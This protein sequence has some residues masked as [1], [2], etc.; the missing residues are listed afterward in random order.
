MQEEPR[1]S[2]VNFRFTVLHAFM[3]VVNYDEDIWR[4]EWVASLKGCG[5]AVLYS[6]LLTTGTP[7]MPEGVADKYYVPWYESTDL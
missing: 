2:T 4:Q 5:P 1:R 6:R 7:A 3:I